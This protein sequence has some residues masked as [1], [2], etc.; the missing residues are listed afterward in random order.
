M[1]RKELQ[2][3]GPVIVSKCS[4]NYYLYEQKGDHSELFGVV[5]NPQHIPIKD[6]YEKKEFGLL[7]MKDS[8]GIRCYKYRG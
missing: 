7:R 5:V 1:D 8:N 3:S 6:D 2:E 4:E